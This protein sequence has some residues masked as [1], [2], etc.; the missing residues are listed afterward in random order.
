MWGYFSAPSPHDFNAIYGCNG[1][2]RLA[3]KRSSHSAL[4]SSPEEDDKNFA[5][6]GAENL[7]ISEN[8]LSKKVRILQ[9]LKGFLEHHNSPIAQICD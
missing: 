2:I 5:K 9:M 3:V 8:E 1:T 4:G 7:G 6:T